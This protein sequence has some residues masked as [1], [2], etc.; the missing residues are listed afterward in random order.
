MKDPELH[1]KNG[2]LPEWR[3][4]VSNML[5]R[6]VA[7][8]IFKK[9]NGEIRTMD[10]TLMESMLAVDAKIE[11]RIGSTLP[12]KP[13]PDVLSVWDIEKDDWRSF[14]WDRVCSVKYLPAS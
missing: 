12:R 11:G 7:R 4:D 13:N 1:E 3:E 6:R 8:V 9:A 2:A 5:K 14:R 10:C